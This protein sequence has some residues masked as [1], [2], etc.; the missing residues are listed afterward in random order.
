MLRVVNCRRAKGPMPK[1]CRRN[2]LYYRQQ[3]QVED[4]RQ[5]RLTTWHLQLSG[6]TAP[7]RTANFLANT[8]RSD[9]VRRLVPGAPFRN[10][11]PK[12]AD[13]RMGIRGGARRRT[14]PRLARY[15]R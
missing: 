5:S 15:H 10:T 7:G 2:L 12:C 9:L 11:P 4:T 8:R 6:I 3:A 14:T 1:Q 13:F